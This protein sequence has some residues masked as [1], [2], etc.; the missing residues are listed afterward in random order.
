MQLVTILLNVV[1][2]LDSRMTLSKKHFLEPVEKKVPNQEAWNLRDEMVH[3]KFGDFFV[4]S[5]F[6]YW[7]E[8][9]M[10]WNQSCFFIYFLN[11]E[12]W[13]C[14]TSKEKALFYHGILR[15]DL[16]WMK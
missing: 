2:P 14:H 16:Q 12:F 8:K 13:L 1:R 15:R 4:D 7:V 11:C 3:M 6:W 9:W 5:Y 10:G